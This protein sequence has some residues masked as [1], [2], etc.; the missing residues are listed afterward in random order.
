[1][2]KPNK[3]FKFNDNKIYI[4]AYIMQ[5]LFVNRKF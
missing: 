2:A 3:K 1:M 5:W 4:Y